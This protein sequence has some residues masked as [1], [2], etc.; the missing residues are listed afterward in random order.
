[1]DY[2]CEKH[3]HRYHTSTTQIPSWKTQQC[4]QSSQDLSG[5]SSEQRPWVWRH[6]SWL[7]TGSSR[8][9]SRP[10]RHTRVPA[11]ISPSRERLG[12]LWWWRRSRQTACPPP[13]HQHDTTS[14][15]L[16]LEVSRQNHWWTTLAQTVE[17]V[18]R[19][20]R[21]PVTTNKER[22]CHLYNLYLYDR[23]HSVQNN[24]NYAKGMCYIRYNR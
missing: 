8:S 20:C 12:H 3:Y 17:P 22:M 9:G 6:G 15:L 2:Q 21:L 13:P 16:P 10:L 7:A 1:M 24:L 11:K 23:R 18:P 4:P 19:D 5:M 14:R